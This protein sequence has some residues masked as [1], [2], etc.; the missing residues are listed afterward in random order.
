MAEMTLEEAQNKVFDVD[1]LSDAEILRMNKLLQAE[2]SK[3]NATEDDKA[4]TGIVVSEM[5]TRL[6]A[7]SQLESFELGDLDNVIAMAGAVSSFSVQADMAKEVL[8]KAQAQKASLTPEQLNE[9]ALEAMMKDPSYS[10]EDLDI[11]LD[12]GAEYEQEILNNKEQEAVQETGENEAE[13]KAQDKQQEEDSI[14]KIKEQRVKEGQEAEAKLDKLLAYAQANGFKTAL[15]DKEEII[16]HTFGNNPYLDNIQKL[17]NQGHPK[18]EI[19][20][21]EITKAIRTGQATQ[22]SLADKDKQL[23]ANQ[24]GSKEESEPERLNNAILSSTK[25]RKE[26]WNFNAND[27]MDEM[28]AIN[29]GL[30]YLSKY[31][32]NLEDIPEAD[33]EAARNLAE[34]LMNTADPKYKDAIAS[35]ISRLDTLTDKK[36]NATENNKTQDTTEVSVGNITPE[37]LEANDKILDNIPH[38]LSID[39]NGNLVN[40]E[41]ED[42][43][44]ALKNL[45]FTDD[46]GKELSEEEQNNARL[47][48][49]EAAQLEA[50]TYAR[51][52]G[53]GNPEDVKKLYYEHFKEALQR[54]VVAAAFASDFQKGMTKEQ[55]AAKFAQAVEKPQKANL[56]AVRAVAANSSVQSENLKD[57]VK[58]KVKSIPVVQKMTNKIKAFDEKMTKRYGKWYTVTRDITVNLAKVGYNV[59]K[60]GALSAIAGSNAPIVFAALA[61]K[62]AYDTLYTMRKEAKSQGKTFGQYFKE[63]KFKVGFTC[64]TTVASLG[65]AALGFNSEN[66][67]AK[68]KLAFVSRSL[69]VVK[70]AGPAFLHT[71]SGLYKK[72]VK[73]DNEGASVDFKKSLGEWKQSG[74]ALLGVLAGREF[75][76]E[77]SE[78]INDVKD[79]VTE[80]FGGAEAQ[81]NVTGES[82]RVEMSTPTAQM[83][84]AEMAQTLEHM[85]LHPDEIAHMNPM[86]MQ[87]YI[88]MNP[89]DFQAAQEI[90]QDKD[91]D[92]IADV[93]DVDHGQGW[94]TANETQLGRLMDADP[95]KVNALLNDGEWHSS[96]ELKEMMENGK[97]NDEQLKAI[98]GL[99][100]R[101]FDANGHI[102]DSDLKAYYENLAKEAAAKEA[103]EEAARSEAK[104]QEPVSHQQQEPEMS[105]DDKRAYAAIMDIISKGEDMNNPEVRASVEGLAKIHLQDIKDAMANGDGNALATKIAT[106]HAQGENQEIAEATQQNEDDSRRMRHAKEDVLE[107][108]AK[109]D[110]AHAALEQDPNN[111]KLQK[112]VAE[113]E[114]KFDKESLDLEQRKLKEADSELKDQ[115]KQDEKAL[116]GFDRAYETVEN[117]FGISEEQVNKSLAA[118]G[119]DVNNLPQDMSSLPKEAQDLLNIKGMYDKAHTLETQLQDRVETNEQNREDI[120]KQEE[121]SKADEKGVKKGLGLDL[122][123]QER[124]PGQSQVENSELIHSVKDMLNPSKEAEQAQPVSEEQVETVAPANNEVQH[125]NVESKIGIINY[126]MIE[127]KPVIGDNVQISTEKDSASLNVVKAELIKEEQAQKGHYNASIVATKANILLQ[128]SVIANDLSER[129]AAGEKI[130]G[131]QEFID[132]NNKALS[133]YGLE[134]DE[135]GGIVK[136]GEQQ[137]QVS[138][139]YNRQNQGYDR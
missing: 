101:E 72:Y 85:G 4:A 111:A 84:P 8:A 45:T 117:K 121:A 91:G 50:E 125:Y 44:T 3:E 51:A 78:A 68:S 34:T 87:Q 116:G 1:K 60:Y 30:E 115:I 104:D 129:L 90:M 79:Y 122:A 124:L 112:E 39:G 109:L 132:K 5:R 113:L 25:A 54:N 20:I 11:A 48:L 77:A 131:A 69:M 99:A 86:E 135:N 27:A 66:A 41:F 80:T 47:S 2:S 61:V 76:A 56:T 57:K 81:A 33:R 12:A 75:S 74:M 24:T 133:K 15:D 40:K 21:Y 22:K 82:S 52:A 58:D 26:K 94:A 127:G 23:E 35:F 19:D 83:T 95:A 73:K 107:A 98:H 67:D 36:G 62:G 105:A 70:H 130:E 42:E 10:K 59:T 136:T 110:A 46:N 53:N 55:I 134:R 96:A 16:K 28:F 37:Q 32:N 49:I 118:M 14:R 43:V 6:E 138:N 18:E 137:K 126:S 97:F 71:A 31:T 89:Q 128:N 92:G 9:A 119:I 106:L 100:T 17:W 114:K 123:A 108:K 139:T 93:Y 7:Y 63:N 13:N 103:A 29:S 64:A 120:H 65:G 102:I 38:P 88:A